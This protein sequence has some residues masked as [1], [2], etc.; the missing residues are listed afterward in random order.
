MEQ[1]C[2]SITFKGIPSEH[3]VIA[4]VTPEFSSL[5]NIDDVA[6]WVVVGLGWGGLLVIDF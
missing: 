4:T 3:L 2:A 6:L 5:R 1:P